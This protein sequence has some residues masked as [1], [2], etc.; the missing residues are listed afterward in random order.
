MLNLQQWVYELTYVTETTQK[1]LL[2]YTH[3]AHKFATLN[4]WQ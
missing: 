3:F 4:Q 1:N 2:I